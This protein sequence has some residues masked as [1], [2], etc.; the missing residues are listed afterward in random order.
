[1]EYN[2]YIYIYTSLYGD[3]TMVIRYITYN[4]YCRYIST[5][6]VGIYHG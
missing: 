4:F 6:V 3:I 5:I 2:G 1:M